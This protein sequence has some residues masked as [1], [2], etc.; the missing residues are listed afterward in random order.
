MGLQV[1]GRR[2]EWGAR[3]M[4]VGEMGLVGWCLRKSETAGVLVRTLPVAALSSNAALT[5]A[6]R[7]MRATALTQSL[8]HI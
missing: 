8:R 1:A 6:C 2:K 5:F 7:N 4:D 3:E